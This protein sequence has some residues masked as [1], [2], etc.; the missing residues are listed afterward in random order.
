M[1]MVSI[2]TSLILLGLIIVEAV[3]DFTGE[4]SIWESVRGILS[5]LAVFG[6]VY[7][8]ML[9]WFDFESKKILR[10]I[11]NV[12]ESYHLAGGADMG[13]ARRHSH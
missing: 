7:G 8:V 6:G 11:E 5:G 4:A 12:F 3:F 2:I 10:F 1:A 9:I 13:V